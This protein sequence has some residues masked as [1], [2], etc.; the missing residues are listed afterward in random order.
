M[1]RTFAS[2][3][4]IPSSGD[5]LV[6]YR[7]VGGGREVFRFASEA[8]RTSRAA[9]NPRLPVTSAAIALSAAVERSS[10]LPL[11][12]SAPRERHRIPLPATFLSA[13]LRRRRRSRVSQCSCAGLCTSRTHS[14]RLPGDPSVAIA[15]SAAVEEVFASVPRGS[16]PRERHRIAAPNSPAVATASC[17]VET[18]AA[19]WRRAV[20]RRDLLLMG[21]KGSSRPRGAVSGSKQSERRSWPVNSRQVGQ[22]IYRHPSYGNYSVPFRKT[23]CVLVR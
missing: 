5:L 15:P 19:R 20:Y 1:L 16:A 2:G 12:C 21:S 11:R 13:S 17:W 14:S 7:S 8:L 6:G 18:Q 3:T 10:G 22:S 23:P 9:P 4:Q